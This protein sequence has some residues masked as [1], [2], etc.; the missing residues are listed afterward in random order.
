[1][2]DPYQYLFMTSRQKKS[3]TNFALEKE[4]AIS[5]SRKMRSLPFVFLIENPTKLR[6]NCHW[7]LFIINE[8]I[9]NI[10]IIYS[11]TN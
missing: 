5:R 4:M 6:I 11:V 9:G 2:S 1:M 3:S 8:I 7:P 10:I